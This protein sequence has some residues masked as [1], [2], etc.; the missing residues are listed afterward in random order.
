MDGCREIWGE[1]EGAEGFREEGDGGGR[2]AEAGSTDNLV[3]INGKLGKEQSE[4]LEK[5][6]EVQCINNYIL[7]PTLE[8]QRLQRGGLLQ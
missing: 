2:E 6:R 8:A 4:G 5:N 7:Q 1:R 3:E